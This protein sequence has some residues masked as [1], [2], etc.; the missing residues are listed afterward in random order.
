[1]APQK[2][3]KASSHSWGGIPLVHQRFANLSWQDQASKWLNPSHDTSS[4]LAH[5][6]GRSYGDSALNSAGTCL[7]TQTLDKRIAFDA[8]TGVLTCEAGITLAALLQWL[9][10][11]GWFLPVTPGTQFVSLGG[12]VANDVHGKNH[13]HMGSFGC[14]VLAFGLTRSDGVFTCSTTEN[15]ELFCA[16]IG[17]LGLTG[18]ITWVQL[19]LIRIPSP[20]L[21]TETKK[22]ANL[23]DFFQFSADSQQDEYTVAWIDSQA[24]GR[25]LG[26]GHFIRGNFATQGGAFSPA[27]AVQPGARRNTTIDG[28]P[29]PPK[30]RKVSIPC[31]APS[32]ALNTASVWCFNQLYYHRQRQQSRCAQTHYQPFFY[33]LDA[34]YHWN[35]IYGRRGF[36]QYQC[37]VPKDFHIVHKILETIANSGLSSFLTVLKAFGEKR[38][39]GLL[40]FPRPGITYA[41]DFPNT[42]AAV[43]SLFKQL[44]EIV[45]KAGGA[46]YPAKDA[47]MSPE[48]F[49]ASFPR[50]KEF[51]R[52]KDPACDSDFWRRVMPEKGN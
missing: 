7:R 3:L 8:N 37:V 46:L 43:H 40:S 25:A 29:M 36:Y 48:M 12:A 27:L 44:D 10:P 26:R 18:I 31:F 15:T 39:P 23:E 9:V 32:F 6:C 24:T 14:H 35:R 34:V 42:G 20:W 30:Q 4:I 33:P 16:T 49:Q 17:G 28:Q 47:R 19:Q 45:I 21:E 41:L 51:L 1:M 50:L 52:L 5:G 13:H 22:M 38:S 2:P 11:Q